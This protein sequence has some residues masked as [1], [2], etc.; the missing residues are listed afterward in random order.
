MSV[1]TGA[2]KCGM[3]SY[4][5]SSSIFGS[6]SISR[7]SLGVDLYSNDRIIALIATD[8]PEPVVPATS[9]C[10]IRARSAHTGMPEMSLPSAIAN[11]EV[12]FA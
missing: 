2:S 1:T 12:M 4:T 9:K 6:T 8:L 11:G 5:E 3:P 10:G 7:T